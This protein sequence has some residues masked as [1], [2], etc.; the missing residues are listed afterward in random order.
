MPTKLEN[1]QHE[2]ET[3]SRSKDY[4][5]QNVKNKKNSNI[6][7]VTKK[8]ASRSFT[9]LR[10]V[11]WVAISTALVWIMIP[12]V[13][14][15]YSG[16]ARN[17]N[18]LSLIMLCFLCI[19]VVSVQNGGAF[20]GD[21]QKAFFLNINDN[22][23]PSSDG[24]PELAFAIYQGMFA[25]ITPAL[26]IG[27]AAERTR[28]VPLLIFIFIWS[29]LVYDVIACWCWSRHGWFSTLGGLDFA[30]GTPVHIT[31]GAAAL[32]YCIV[33]GKRNGHGSDEFKPHN[34]ANV[35]LG[36]VLLW[37]GWFGFN[38]G[39]ALGANLRAISAMVASNLAASIGGLTWMLMDYR[40]ERKFSALGFCSG[41]IAGLVC[42][43]P[44]SGYVTPA[45]SIAFGVCG[46]IACNLAV[47]LKH[48][49]DFDDALDVFAVHG[50]GGV[51]G[52]ILTGIFAQR[53]VSLLGGT[54]IP[55]GGM[56]DGHHVQ[57]AYQ[58]ASS[59]AGLGEV[60]YYFVDKVKTSCQQKHDQKPMQMQT[61][62]HYPK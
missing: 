23:S 7:D 30:G 50:V 57:V 15:F 25:A 48:I 4:Y 17:K 19:P 43:T 28:T 55:I 27:A 54:E 56:L 18:A 45:S 8:S 29:T 16:M 6:I 22:P 12:G 3:M 39:S 20:I 62:N 35:V 34:I 10:D 60:A 11:G 44:G 1:H 31:S 53:S 24:I 40:L 58:L 5:N 32:A 9:K 51:T 52:N 36:T 2:Q 49:F 42:I 61:T 47:K 46:G 41:A 38:G 13:G 21:L 33:I 26:A 14:F 59:V 37:F